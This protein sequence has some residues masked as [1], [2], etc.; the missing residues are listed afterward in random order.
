V[1]PLRDILARRPRIAVAAIATAI[2]L[3]TIGI[4]GQSHDPKPMDDA[5]AHLAAR[6]THGPGP[7]AQQQIS[8]A[9]M[10]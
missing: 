7:Q 2:A 10:R 5:S 1:S 3:A 4:G 6:A 9:S 8:Y